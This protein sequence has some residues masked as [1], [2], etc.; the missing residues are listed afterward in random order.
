MDGMEPRLIALVNLQEWLET[1]LTL[2]IDAFPR[3]KL[4]NPLSYRR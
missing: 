1:Y 3:F 4:A 2:E